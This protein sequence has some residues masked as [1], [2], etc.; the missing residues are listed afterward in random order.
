[1]A[2]SGLSI[3]LMIKSQEC[4]SPECTSEQVAFIR[5]KLVISEKF[6]QLREFNELDNPGVSKTYRIKEVTVNTKMFLHEA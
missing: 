5:L 4:A 3:V 1:M 2:I 6:M